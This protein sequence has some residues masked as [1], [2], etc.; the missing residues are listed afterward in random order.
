MRFAR[1][2]VA[3]LIAASISLS[4][5]G[6]STSGSQRVVARSIPAAPSYLTPVQVKTPA[7]GED[8]YA[9]AARERAGRLQA[10]RIIVKAAAEWNM[11][12]ADIAAP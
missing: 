10:N 1:S 9:I 8:P 4:L 7:L 6:C 11:V 12:A 2:S 3:A 5:M